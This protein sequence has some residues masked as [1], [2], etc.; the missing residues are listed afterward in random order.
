MGCGLVDL[1]NDGWLDL[2]EAGGGLDTQDAQP[3]RLFR[4]WGGRFLK[5]SNEAGPDFAR[6]RLRGFRPQWG[7]DAAVT[8][9]NAPIEMRWNSS[10]REGPSRHWL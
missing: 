7:M 5:V 3:N 8:A 6:R 9:L 10:L 1:D 4:N 2:F